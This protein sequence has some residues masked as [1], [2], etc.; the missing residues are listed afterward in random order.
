MDKT[1]NALEQDPNCVGWMICN[2]EHGTI[3]SSNGTLDNAQDVAS[4]MAR[5]FCRY[6]RLFLSLSSFRPDAS[7]TIHAQASFFHRRR[8]SLLVP[9]AR[10]NRYGLCVYS[11][12]EKPFS[13]CSKSRKQKSLSWIRR[14]HS[15]AERG[16]TPKTATN[17]FDQQVHFSNLLLSSIS[18]PFFSLSFTYFTYRPNTFTR[19]VRAGNNYQPQTVSFLNMFSDVFRVF[20]LSL[21]RATICYHG[22]FLRNAITTKSLT[23]D[24]QNELPDSYEFSHS[25]LPC[26]QKYS[27]LPLWKIL[28][29]KKF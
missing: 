24:W 27:L 8:R 13:R 21:K 29:R 12:L 25:A 22:L 2:L 19:S 3:I 20:F 7:A 4:T 1:L 16:L 15:L 14:S 18:I 28:R 23:F 17:S 10:S 6:S 9:H 26:P 11:F 5:V